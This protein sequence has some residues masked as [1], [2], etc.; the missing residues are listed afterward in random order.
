[1]EYNG[2]DDY[3]DQD[4][5]E[6]GHGAKVSSR[7]TNLFTPSRGVIWTGCAIVW[8]GLIII[9]IAGSDS[10][11]FIGLILTGT[12]FLTIGALSSAGLGPMGIFITIFTIWLT[13]IVTP[14][15]F[16]LKNGVTSLV[17]LGGCLIISSVGFAFYSAITVEEFIKVFS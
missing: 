12:L 11:F 3:Q 13:A 4:E 8:L 9:S 2:Y 15:Y 14:F 17:T 7:S 5:N 1:M 6:E 10:Q 16:G